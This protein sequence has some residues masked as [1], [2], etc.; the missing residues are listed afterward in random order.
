MVNNS[1]KGMTK[2]CTDIASTLPPNKYWTFWP[3]MVLRL[4]GDLNNEVVGK[5]HRLLV[6]FSFVS[7]FVPLL[8]CIYGL[9]TDLLITSSVYSFVRGLLFGSFLN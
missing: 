3:A 4:A 8:F 5:F 1:P 6:T 7:S 9:S 2:L